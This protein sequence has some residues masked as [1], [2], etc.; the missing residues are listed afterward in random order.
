[1]NEKTKKKIGKLKI[2]SI[3]IVVVLV[4]NIIYSFFAVRNVFDEIYYSVKWVPRLTLT[5]I[6]NLKKLDYE[7]G[8][9]F[10]LYPHYKNENGIDSYIYESYDDHETDDGKYDVTYKIY[11][12]AKQLKLTYIESKIKNEKLSIQYYF[13]YNYNLQ[14]KELVKNF[15][16][17][18]YDKIKD[19]TT[20]YQTDIA[21]KDYCKKNN[22]SLEEIR[23]NSE[24][25]LKEVILKDWVEDN[26]GTTKYNMNNLGKYKVIDKI[27]E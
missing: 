21:I 12:K 11:Y 22:I 16:I 26:Q 15:Y 1:M 13:E 27:G 17:N 24:K 10:K 9:E 3:I 4:I 6:M 14:T 5:S 2:L 25:Y 7:S 8:K 18:Y 20:K 23:I 19:T